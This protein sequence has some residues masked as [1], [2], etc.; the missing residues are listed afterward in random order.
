VN[1]VAAVFFLFVSMLLERWVL[2][3]VFSASG[4]RAD[5][6]VQWPAWALYLSVA[7]VCVVGIG[8]ISVLAYGFISTLAGTN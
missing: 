6:D 7:V 4:V 5:S 3:K 8:G 2:R 1:P